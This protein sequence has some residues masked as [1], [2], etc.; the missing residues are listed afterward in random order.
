MSLKTLRTL[1]PIIVATHPRSGTHL[2]ID[3]IRRHFA[4]TRRRLRPLETPH[5]LYVSL[6]R[7]NQGHHRPITRA[8]F[9]RQVCRSPRTLVKTHSF[10]GFSDVPPEHRDLIEVLMDR[11]Q[12]LSI[13]RDGRRV[14]CSWQAYEHRR[15]PAA[16]EGFSAFI[17][18]PGWGFDDRPTSW[19]A[20]AEA[21]GTVEGMRRFTF[22]EIVGDPEAALDAL[23]D[24]LEER[25]DRRDPLL[26]PR[27]GSKRQIRL[28]RLLGRTASTT[29]PGPPGP[30]VK[31][32]PEAFADRADRA[33]FEERAGRELRAFGY[34]PDDSWVETGRTARAETP[35]LATASSGWSG[36]IDR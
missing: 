27:L 24:L 8:E 18:T 5:N 22:E 17:R 28:A 31:K 7:L 35:R 1:R 2:T 10:P 25:P 16:R 21:W 4:S 12:V 23:A 36:S 9:L 11:A 15:V 26:P 20:H 34:E 29:L 14:L 19:A 32:W 30:P 33:F 3:F 13:V 6:D